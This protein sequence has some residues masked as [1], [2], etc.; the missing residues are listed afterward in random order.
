MSTAIVTQGCANSGHA[1]FHLM[2]KPDP[3]STLA[4]L[5]EADTLV[6]SQF[7]VALLTR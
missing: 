7:Y 4:H 3:N 6:P 2:A 1:N 5:L